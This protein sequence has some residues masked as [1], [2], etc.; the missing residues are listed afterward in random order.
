MNKKENAIYYA[1]IE[2]KIKGEIKDSLKGLI[3]NKV[4]VQNLI[5]KYKMEMKK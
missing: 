2:L 5:N 3:E 4:N 1:K